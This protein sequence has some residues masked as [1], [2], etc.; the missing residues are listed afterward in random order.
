MST[1]KLIFNKVRAKNFRSI[2]NAFLELDFQQS[3]TTLIAS[4]DNGSGKSNMAIWALYYALFDKPY[5]K[6]VKK[7]GLLN[8]KSNKDLV[9][10]LEF[11]TMG[12]KW[13]VRR[14]MK[15]NSLEIFQDEILWKNEA[16][17]E[18][19]DYLQTVIKIDEKAFS[20]IVALGV[21]RFVPFVQMSS[22]ER[23]SFVEQ[24]LDLIVISQMND[25]T[26]T[27]I[28]SIKTALSQIE[29]DTG[30]TES[31]Y[32]GRVRTLNILEE[33]KNQR[34]SESGSE[35]TN[36][37]SEEETITNKIKL[38]DKKLLD[39]SGK[40]N[41]GVNSKLSEVKN[42]IDKFVSKQYDIKRQAESVTHLKDCPTCKQIVSEDHK[43]LIKNEAINKASAFDD[44]VN[45][46]LEQRSKYEAL[47][48]ENN[49]VQKQI[50]DVSIIKSTLNNT[51]SGVSAQIKQIRSKMVNTDEDRLISD[52]IL[53]IDKL[54]ILIEDKSKE[55]DN[56]KK[57][58]IKHT[59]LLQILKDDGI[60]ANIVAQYIPY[61]NQNINK[62]LDRLNL[63]IQINIDSEFNISL[64]APDRKNQTIENLSTGQLR[65]VDIAT[66]L[67]W[68]EIAKSKA[69]LDCNILILDEIL[70]NLSTSGVEE[71]MD[72]WEIVGRDTNLIV[73]SQR[74][75]EFSPYFKR[76]IKY[77]L[78]N[79]MTVEV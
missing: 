45:K 76:E 9:V 11:E 13:L 55:L 56:I 59:Q 42:M 72:M 24:M 3:Q 20:S 62:T 74:S 78:V 49:A 6:G 67:A 12:S 19:Q 21:D 43:E 28:K 71:F 22:Q 25:N 75:D 16:G 37:L 40:L 33:K 41:T 4:K 38:V 66:C 57:E 2:G 64:F 32:S 58:E 15:P 18:P 69:S 68:R 27:R 46:L 52:E 36:L 70:E 8:S 10:E 26:K 51:L 31:K 5:A 35:L 34:L 53:E 77:K 73:I 44:P 7:I 65:R 29:Y 54:K 30:I 39:L 17:R 14:S 47:I 1:N 63:Y 48:I 50:S 60:K 79:D 61:L 23:R